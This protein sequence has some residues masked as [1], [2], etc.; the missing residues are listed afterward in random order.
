MKNVMSIDVE[1]YFQVSAL[2]ES[3]QVSQWDSIKPRVEANTHKILDIFEQHNI[4]ATH[5]VLGWVAKKFPQLI[6]DIH[7]RGHEIASH[8]MSHQL[9]YNQSPAVFKQE[10]LDS[11]ALLED[12][13]GEAVIGAI[14]P[15]ATQLLETRLGR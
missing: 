7:S 10:T 15:L 5:F 11:K 2:A 8:G 13:C 3:I 1:D 6:K 14:V 12:I 9:I 4:K